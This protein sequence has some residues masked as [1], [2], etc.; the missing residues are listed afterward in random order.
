MNAI[1]LAVG[2]AAIACADAIG[3]SSST[4]GEVPRVTLSDAQVEHRAAADG[5]V[6]P[7]VAAYDLDHACAYVGG[8]LVREAAADGSVSYR[9]YIAAR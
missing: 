6:D 7:R 8:S 9:C 3:V 2:L 5:K 4:V 1:V